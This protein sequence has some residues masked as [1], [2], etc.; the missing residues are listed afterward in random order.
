MLKTI[1]SKYNFFY[2]I[3]VH[4]NLLVLLDV[5]EAA[6]KIQKIWRGYRTRVLN[7]KVFSVYQQIQTLRTNQYIM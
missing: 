2:V 5:E 6:I 4:Y 7:P 1:S 3:I